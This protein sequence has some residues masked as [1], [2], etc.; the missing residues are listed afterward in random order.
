MVWT[1]LNAL[2]NPPYVGAL[3][4]RQLVSLFPFGFLI[5]VAAMPICSATISCHFRQPSV[6]CL[7]PSVL[8]ATT[9]SLPKPYRSLSRGLE[10]TIP[11]DGHLDVFFLCGVG[12]ESN[13]SLSLFW[14]NPRVSS[15][16]AGSNIPVA[17]TAAE[18]PNGT[19][20]YSGIRMRCASSTTVLLML[21]LTCALSHFETCVG[22]SVVWGVHLVNAAT[23][24]NK[25]RHNPVFLV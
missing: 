3:F 2:Q 8:S 10:A 17:A 23:T 25:K 7:L 21:L 22:I 12:F 20:L 16:A 1:F 6:A 15:A 13:L 14:Y 19:E 9:L 11:R 18:Q 5:T 24:N 4:S